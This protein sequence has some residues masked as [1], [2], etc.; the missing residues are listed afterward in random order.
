MPDVVKQPIVDFYM[1]PPVGG[2][3]WRYIYQT[4]QVRVLEMQMLSPAS[5]LD[6]ANAESFEAAA[7]SLAGGEYALP[8]SGRNFAKVEDTLLLR[9]TAVREFFS[10]SMIDE[11]IAE[12]FRTRDDFANLRLAVRRT[13]N[14]KP[15]GTDYSTDGNVLPELFEQIFAEESEPDDRPV[16][17]DY[18]QQAVEQAILAYYQQKEIRQV[19]YAIDRCQAEYN[20]K[21]AH[22]LESIFLLG[23]Y[24]IQIDLTNIRTMLRLKFTESEQRN[25]F[26]QGGFI[27]LERL[28]HGLE[29]GY[30]ALGSLFFATPYYRVVETG[31]SYL[32]SNK[33]FLKAEQQCDE[34][35]TGFLKSTIQITVGPQPII[36][37]LLM[38]E[39]EIR[40][41]RLI[42]TAKKNFLDTQLILDRIP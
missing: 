37:F 32:A 25:V 8:Q 14:E 31:A 36:A 34:F 9:R 30:E 21:K 15:L 28:R 5:F 6:M 18:L 17:P 10:D 40:N 22:E 23:L 13:L 24:R 7:D 33:S 11:P 12:M 35:L 42:L 41:V 3:D 29:L 1:Y 20:L 16:F 19:D 4:A 27:E 38:K 2:D 39:N 26:L